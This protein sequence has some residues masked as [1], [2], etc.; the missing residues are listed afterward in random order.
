MTV[1]P[2][3]PAETSGRRGTVQRPW[4][5]HLTGSSAPMFA[6]AGLLLVVV[7]F[8]LVTEPNFASSSNIANL[9]RTS[10]VPI[11]LVVGMTMVILTGGI[12]LSMGGILS[13]CGIAY[14]KMVIAGVPTSLA[15]VLTVLLGAALGIGVNGLLIGRFGLS[16]FVVTLASASVLGG[17]A[18]LWSGNRQ[19][20]M[21]GDGLARAL[22]ND[23]LGSLLPYGAIIAVVAVV[24]AGLVLRY[25]IFGRS[26]YAIGGNQEAAQLSG[27]GGAR[28]I[29]SVYGVSGAC[30]GLASVMM[31]GRQTI[32]DPTAGSSSIVLYV[33][34]AT[35]LAGVTITGGAGSV[36]GA[37]IGTAFLQVLSNALALRGFNNSWQM[38]VTGAILLVAVYLDRVRLRLAARRG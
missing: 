36:Y 33:V 17:I 12:D 22:G 9:L 7:V 13:L 1:T 21:S 11:L 25:T 20:D 28:V 3:V 38:V 32:A 5:R 34:A 4:I 26:V 16:F 10:A 23:T 19:F 27:V 35:L 14:A 29:A 18:L 31:I 2:S 15:L 24:L 30:A 6:V 37:L 8:Q